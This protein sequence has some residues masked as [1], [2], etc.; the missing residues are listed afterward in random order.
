MRMPRSNR[1]VGR[2]RASDERSQIAMQN[3]NDDNLFMANLSA[4]KQAKEAHR[5]TGVALNRQGRVGKQE[6]QKYKELGD[7]Y[8]PPKSV[9]RSPVRSRRKKN[10]AESSSSSESESEDKEEEMPDN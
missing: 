5:I 7:L 9:S 3:R 1:G 10:R 4:M 2:G 6:L 8:V